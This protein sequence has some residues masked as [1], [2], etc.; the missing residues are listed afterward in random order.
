MDVEGIDFW[1]EEHELFTMTR[2]FRVCVYCN[3]KKKDRDFFSKR[4]CKD[5]NKD[6]I[7]HNRLK[8]CIRNLINK[9]FKKR[10][11]TKKSKTHEIIGCSFEDFKIYLESKFEPWMNWE[12]RGKI[13][14]ELNY[15][16][17]LDHI[18]PLSSAKNEE[19]II[20]LNHHT[21]FQPLCSY[22]NRYIKRNKINY[23]IE[24]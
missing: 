7:R 18:I 20:R 24:L 5:C 8:L 14:D 11:Y 4:K 17:D 2:Y 23:N 12:N 10:G 19:D 13:S 16:W 6:H 1:L 9:S 3:L 15:G 21:N 22:T